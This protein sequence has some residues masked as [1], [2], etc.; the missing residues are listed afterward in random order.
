MKQEKN[1]WD[2]ITTNSEVIPEKATPQG[3]SDLP[4]FGRQILFTFQTFLLAL[5]GWLCN[6]STLEEGSERV[7][8]QEI[9]KK[10]L[11]IPV[12]HFI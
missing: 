2:P 5:A 8:V 11:G 1:S 4:T 9:F 3:R 10:H 6:V 12:Q 7:H